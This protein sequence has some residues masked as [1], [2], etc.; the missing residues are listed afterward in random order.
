MAMVVE[1]PLANTQPTACVQRKAEMSSA[2]CIQL[3]V[4]QPEAISEVDTGE[5]RLLLLQA[6]AHRVRQGCLCCRPAGSLGGGGGCSA[7]GAA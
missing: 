5:A 4:M 3:L 2:S 1:C 7:Q 6:G